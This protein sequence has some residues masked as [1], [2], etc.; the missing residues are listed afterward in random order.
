MTKLSLVELTLKV[1]R[2][3]KMA[4]GMARSREKSQMSAACRTM[5]VGLLGCFLSRGLTIALYLDRMTDR[6]YVLNVKFHLL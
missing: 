6:L 5:L 3:E 4:S 1:W 2:S